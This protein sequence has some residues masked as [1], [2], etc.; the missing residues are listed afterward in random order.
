MK[1]HLV[2]GAVVLVGL[3]VYASDLF[4]EDKEA[5]Q[6]FDTVQK[7]FQSQS[8]RCIFVT[9]FK[10]CAEARGPCPVAGS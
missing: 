4:A 3:A 1:R 5:V 6:A 2:L 7:V 8:P 10:R 9:H